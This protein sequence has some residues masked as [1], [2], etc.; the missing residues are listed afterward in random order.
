MKTKKETHSCVSTYGASSQARTRS[1][2]SGGSRRNEQ[3]LLGRGEE[4]QGRK[5]LGSGGNDEDGPCGSAGSEQKNRKVL[6]KV[7]ETG[8]QSWAEW[9]H[10]VLDRETAMEWNRKGWVHEENL[11]GTGAMGRE[12]RGTE[13]ETGGK[14]PGGPGRARSESRCC[15]AALGRG[16]CGHP[17]RPESEESKRQTSDPAFRRATEG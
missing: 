3:V 10:P 15:I 7:E 6:Y 1:Q 9:S 2:P 11:A 13:T 12:G 5:S 17:G 8:L 16:P 14:D 4:E